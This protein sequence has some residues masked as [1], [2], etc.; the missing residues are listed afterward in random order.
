[1]SRLRR[2]SAQTQ[3][4]LQPRLWIGLIGLGLLILYV[5]AF[6]ARNDDEVDLDFVFFTAR[7]GLIWLLLLGFALGL[8]VGLVASQLYRRRRRNRSG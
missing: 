1:M 3:E 8:A 6:I 4:E 2:P 7:V 5:V